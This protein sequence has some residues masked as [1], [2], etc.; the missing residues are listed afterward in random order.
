MKNKQANLLHKK[1]ER[2]KKRYNNNIRTS[3]DTR[4]YERNGQSEEFKL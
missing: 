2:E 1:N 3:K 4:K